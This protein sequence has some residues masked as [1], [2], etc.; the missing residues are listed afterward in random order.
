MVWFLQIL[1]LA[2]IASASPGSKYK[3]ESGGP[4]PDTAPAALRAAVHA[5]SSR[6]VDAQGQPYLEFWF[7][8][9]PLPA[10]TAPEDSAT[11]SSIRHGAFLGILQV[12][13]NVS[14]RR[15]D[16][17]APGAYALRLSFHPV[18]GAHQGIAPQ[19]DFL[20]LTALAASPDPAATPG[21]PELMK[22]AQKASGTNH[23]WS[24]SCW[25]QDTE[26]QPGLAAHGENDHVLQV[27]IGQTPVAVIVAGKAE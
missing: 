15:G 27:R 1:L 8:K 5:T 19:R 3:L 21:F 26:F 14:D 23:P 22:L 17:I 25:K 13:K 4:A 16:R 11:L 6:I 18:D 2:A 20:I 9:G 12:G 7:T 24:L 10:S